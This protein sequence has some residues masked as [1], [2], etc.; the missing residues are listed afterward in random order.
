[1]D[2]ILQIES[3]EPQFIESKWQSHWEETRQFVTDTQNSSKPKYYA[4]SMFPYPSGRLHMGHVRN[5]TITDVMA[6]IKKMQ[7]FEVLHPMGW[8]S[9]GLPAENA[10]IK[11]NIPPGEWTFSNIDYMREQLKRLGLSYDWDREVLTCRADYYR[12]TQWIF[13]YLYEKG[14]AYKKEAPVNWCE[15]CHTVLANEQVIDGKCWRDDS[16]V[17]KKFLS[18]WFFKIT[19]YAERLLE[20]LPQLQGWPDRVTLMQKNWINKSQGAEIY[21]PLETPVSGIDSKIGI[22]TT[23]PDTIYGVTYLVLAPEHPMV[24]ALTLA[25]QKEAVAQYRLE[26]QR[27]SEIER[28]STEREKTGVPLGTFVIN[29]FTDEKI[30]LWI[31]DYALLEYGTGAVMAVPAHDERDFAFAK[32]F[33]MPIKRV[34]EKPG[35]LGLPLEDAYTDPGVL[36]ASGPFTGLDSDEGKRKIIAHTEAQGWGLGKIQYRLRD[37]LVSRQRYWGA[38]IPIVYCE[39]CG[40]VPVPLNALPVNLPEDV[41]FSVTGISPV[42]TSKTFQNTPCPQCGGVAR[43]ETDTMDT[44]VCSSWYYL[45][46]LDPLNTEKP[47]DPAIIKKWMPVDQYVGGIEHAILH[48]M[49]SRFLMMALHDGDWTGGD[50]PFKNLLTQGMVLKDGSKM[51]K[52]KG[53]TVDPDAIFKAFGADT[54]RFFIL[55]DSPP[56]SDFDWKDSAVEGCFKFLNRVWRT[57][58]ENRRSISVSVEI[59]KSMPPYGEMSPLEREIYQRIHRTIAGVSEDIQKEFQFNTVISKIRELVNYLSRLELDPNKVSPVFSHAVVNLLKLLAPIAPHLCEDLWFQLGGEDVGS[60]H[61]QSWPVADP[62]ALVSDTVEVVVQVNGKL[63]DKFQ[64]ANGLPK[65]ELEQEAR[66]LAKVVPYL[67]NQQVVKVIVVP[68]KLVNFVVKP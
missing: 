68:N 40:T 16:P 34:I 12:W 32:K 10:A 20:N 58:I 47:F 49:Y 52:S 38:P 42:A 21:F 51:S 7:G 60:I 30:P 15:E 9:F 64:V 3:Y 39:T 28:T 66:L 37:W 53:N 41:D 14:L 33:N 61:L 62:Q 8:D 48:L 19:A 31:A 6:R 36:I 13:L 27:K 1:M 55:S 57:V 5:Y 29:P 35:F 2:S 50:E 11:H 45:R 65:E 67:E 23:R 43:R 22:F 63:R 18:Q 26:A 56:Q 46:F 4:L 17:I 54:A 44:F 24:D 59:E 25:S